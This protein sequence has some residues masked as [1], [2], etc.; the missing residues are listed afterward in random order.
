MTK[1]MRI[2]VTQGDIEKGEPGEP[3]DCPI[4]H[5]LKRRGFDFPIVKGSSIYL[6]VDLNRRIPLPHKVRVWIR[7][8]D[9]GVPVS[10]IWFDMEY[11]EP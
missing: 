3:D 7:R 10:P 11:E 5:S 8:F 6:D 2:V 9:W 4:Y 1:K